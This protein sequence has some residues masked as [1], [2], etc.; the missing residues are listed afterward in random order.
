MDVGQLNGQVD[1]LV[2]GQ[3]HTVHQD[4]E[5]MAGRKV[6][7]EQEVEVVVEQEVEVVVQQEVEVEV[8]SGRVI[9]KMAEKEVRSGEAVD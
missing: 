6:Q 4:E 8:E 7:L 5:P 9:H 2:L 3:M 1:Q